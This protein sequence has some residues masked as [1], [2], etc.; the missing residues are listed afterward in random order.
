M[1]RNPPLQPN[2]VLLYILDAIVAEKLPHDRQRLK[3]ELLPRLH[4]KLR[5]GRYGTLARSCEEDVGECEG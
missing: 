3:L 1:L 2:T 5:Q 4:E